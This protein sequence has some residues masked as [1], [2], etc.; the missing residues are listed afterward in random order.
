MVAVEI[1]LEA[2]AA[3]GVAEAAGFKFYLAWHRNI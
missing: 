2:S 1:V 3:V